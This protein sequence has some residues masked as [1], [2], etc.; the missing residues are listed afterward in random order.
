MKHI[1]LL[2]AGKSAT[3]LIDY[4]KQLTTDI[5]CKV[6]VADADLHTAQK[7]VGEHP[8][9]SAQQLNIEN[10]AFRKELIK[11]ADIVI[12]LLPA[13]LHYLIA[14]DCLEFGKHLLTASY[15]DEKIKS[16]E[17]QIKAKGLL[18][19]YEMGLDP[20]ID[21][22]SAMR[23]IHKIK[24]KGGN[25]TSFKSHCGGL[26][27]PESDTNPWHY[28]IS[29][30]PRNLIIAGKAGAVY[31]KDG[32][33]KSLSYT[34]LFSLNNAVQ[35]DG[36]MYAWYPNRDSVSYIPIY[37]LQ[38]A[39]TF[40]R[41]TVRHPEFIF[42]WKN[43]I[44]LKLTDEQKIYET[45]GMSLAGF[46]K[47]HF[48]KHGFGEWLNEMLLSRLAMAK[49]MMEKLMELIEAEEQ[50]QK[51]GAE[52]PEEVM[53]V[54]EKG[55]LNAVEIED[56]KDK[57]AEAVAIKMHEAN[58][59]MKQLFFLGMDDNTI[60]INKGLAS[61]ADVL[62]F[63]FETKFELQPDD[64]DMVVMLHEIDY[65]KEGIKQRVKSSL[66]VAGENATHTAMAKTVGLPLGIAAKLILDEKLKVT[67]LCIPA[68][69]EI[70]KPVLKEL[71]LNGIIF[72]ATEEEIKS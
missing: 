24:A 9:V 21:H 58:L 46:F 71:E 29:W 65:E 20:G 67:G 3:V 62:Q 60:I 33:V 30:N 36:V 23:I 50:A 55:E 14:V 1:L 42:G 53:L 37:Q 7:K 68:I 43:I 2:G 44:D 54:D 38:E 39:H 72:N 34:N 32:E 41:T 10:E 15:V 51:A 64:K 4:L 27:A 6:T 57:A 49:D 17:L 45:D 35:I 26:V 48:E 40:I 66:V 70:Y 5:I 22:M 12:S 8:L 25:I 61:A 69:E 47:Q 16:L 31:K 19:L 56:I 13:A 28:K 52:A 63:I 11:N 59:S 18:F